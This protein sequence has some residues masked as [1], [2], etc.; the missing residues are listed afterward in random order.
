MLFKP[1]VEVKLNYQ[2]L[3]EFPTCGTHLGETKLVTSMLGRPACESRSTSSILA[4][5]GTISF[6]FCRP[7]LGPTS[8]TF[9]NDGKPAIWTKRYLQHKNSIKPVIQLCGTTFLNNIKYVLLVFTFKFK[10]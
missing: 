6:S 1:A 8:T 2:S 5:V 7:S 10:S 3:K 4:E 9:T